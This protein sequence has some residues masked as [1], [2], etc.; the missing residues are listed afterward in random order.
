[1]SSSP[2]NGLRSAFDAGETAL[3]V[4]DTT[5]SPRVVELCGELGYDFVWLDLEHGGP[6]PWDGDTLEGFARA[7]ELSDTEL[8]VRIPEPTPALVRKTLDAGVR[9]LFVSHVETAA[10]AERVAQAARY[11]YDG[12][13]GDRGLAS[14]RASR[15]GLV[16]DYPATED[17]ETL[18][19]VTIESRAAVENIDDICAVPELGFV[20]AGP[21]D[22]SV[23]HGTPGKYDSD[24]VLDDVERVRDAALGAGTPVGN[25]AFGVEDA[26]EKREQGY[27]LLNVGNTMGAIKSGLSG[28]LDQLR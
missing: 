20:F 2:R 15:W 27:S 10:E 17:R 13:P 19:G 11:D 23:S 7:A 28:T 24:A 16:G 8:L 25:L 26:R 4:I 1:M 21:L 22:L 14:P 9:N 3:G 12:E 18:V 5:Y 6:S